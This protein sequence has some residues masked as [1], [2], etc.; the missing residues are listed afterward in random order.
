MPCAP[1]PAHAVNW[2]R[3]TSPPAGIL[4]CFS[5]L[6]A[7]VRRPRALRDLWRPRTAVADVPLS[8]HNHGVEGDV[9]I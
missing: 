4:S 6:L 3:T 9:A 2:C 8:C 1:R 5:R 7:Q